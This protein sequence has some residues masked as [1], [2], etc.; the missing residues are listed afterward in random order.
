MAL[1]CS[2]A[3]DRLANYEKIPVNPRREDNPQWKH[4]SDLYSQA[5][6]IRSRMLGENHPET[7]ACAQIPTEDRHALGQH[8]Q[9][10]PIP[11]LDHLS[12]Q[13]RRL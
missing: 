7:L 4:V 13:A 9:A 6:E 10:Q 11:R 5:K 3:L 2:M 12:A 8:D 1:K